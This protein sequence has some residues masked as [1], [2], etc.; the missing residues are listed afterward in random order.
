MLYVMCQQ[1]FQEHSILLYGALGS[2]TEDCCNHFLLFVGKSDLSSN[3]YS[4]YLHESFPIQV[5][6][7]W[8]YTL[9]VA[10][11]VSEFGAEED[12]FKAMSLLAELDHGGKIMGLN[13]GLRL[14]ELHTAQVAE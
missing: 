1:K 10:D 7:E 11:I 13:M 4:F 14:L 3:F 9:P 8:M 6:A 5:I 2:E 12:E